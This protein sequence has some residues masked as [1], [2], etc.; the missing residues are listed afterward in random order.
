MK[1]FKTLLVSGALAFAATAQAAP[2]TV[3][4]VTWDPDAATD[5]TA[6]SVNMRQFLNAS[7]GEL[8]GF[9]IVTA[10]NGSFNFCSGCELTFQYSGFMPTGGTT[11][12]GVGETINYSGGNVKFYVGATEV[13]NPADYN[14]LTWENTGNGSL[15]LDLVNSTTFLGTNLGL[16]LSGVGYLDVLE[17][18]TGLANAYFNTNT[19]KDG[20]DFAFSTSLTFFRDGIND[21]SGTGNMFSDSINVP[22]PASLALVGLGLLGAGFSRRKTAKK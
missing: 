2:V 15:W 17:S 3:G 7:T 22:E 20:S 16:I 13:T 14:A 6:Q 11:V 1:L 4:G 10:M 12:P 8:T 21:V 19:Q 9:G 5:F 18:G